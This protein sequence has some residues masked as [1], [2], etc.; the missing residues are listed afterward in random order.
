MSVAS[1]PARRRGGPR[2][3]E[4]GFKVNKR[5]GSG[6]TAVALD[7]VRGDRTG[8]LK[9]ARTVDHNDR[10]LDEVGSSIN[11]DTNTSSSCMRL[12]SVESPSTLP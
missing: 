6:S 7:V 12:S 1:S 9:V 4:H 3:L 5:L 8:V 10:L 2:K 11:C